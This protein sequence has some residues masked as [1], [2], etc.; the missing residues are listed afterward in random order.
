MQEE[1]IVDWIRVSITQFVL[2]KSCSVAFLIHYFNSLALSV[3]ETVNKTLSS[4]KIFGDKS[5]VLAKFFP[6]SM[7]CHRDGTAP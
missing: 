6:L 4:S 2:F 3:D 7:V 5:S 1:P